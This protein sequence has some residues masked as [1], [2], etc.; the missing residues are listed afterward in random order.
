MHRT[1]IAGNGEPVPVIEEFSIH[2]VDCSMLQSGQACIAHAYVSAL[3][4]PAQ[5]K[6]IEVHACRQS[7]YTRT[8]AGQNISYIIKHQVHIG[9]TS[10][11]VDRV[12]MIR[13]AT[14][15]ACKQKNTRRVS[16]SRCHWSFPYCLQFLL[17]C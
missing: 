3:Y 14:L 6:R 10:P 7:I 16:T 11:H 17:E 2:R 13:D 9:W 5:N 1:C 8:L 12:E 15:H 4:I